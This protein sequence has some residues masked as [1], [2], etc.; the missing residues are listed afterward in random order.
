M[1]FQA[2]ANDIIDDQANTIAAL[3]K[4]L[5]ILKSQLKDAEKQLAEAS[6]PVEVVEAPK[7]QR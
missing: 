6:S 7:K 5:A 1:P 2:D 4:D 3:Y